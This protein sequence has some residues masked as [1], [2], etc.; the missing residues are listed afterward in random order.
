MRRSLIVAAA[1]LAGMLILPL[2]SARAAEWVELASYKVDYKKDR[3]VIEIGK[4]EGRF[5]KVRL[6]VKKGDMILDKL[7]FTFGDGETFE[8]DTKV[9]FKEGSSTR[10]IDLPGS[11]RIIKKV[12][13]VC[14]SEHKHDPA[15]L[16][17]YGKEK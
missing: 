16:I 12:E 9:E 15:T 13:F 1:V 2:L 17:L 7:K 6:E 11:G 14:K 5:T 8:P 3:E 10:D 4:S